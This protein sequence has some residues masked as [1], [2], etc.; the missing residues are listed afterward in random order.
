MGMVFATPYDKFHINQF[1]F[2][3][4]VFD[5]RAC[6]FLLKHL[7]DEMVILKCEKIKTNR[8]G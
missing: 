7:E 8:F 3:I 1:I 2:M 5:I 4:T 6:E